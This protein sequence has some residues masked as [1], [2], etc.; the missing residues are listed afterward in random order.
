M[1]FS[2]NPTLTSLR[3]A[4]TSPHQ[5]IPLLTHPNLY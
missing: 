1:L 5:Y 2:R 4:N 3:T